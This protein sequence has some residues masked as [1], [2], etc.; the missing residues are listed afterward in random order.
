[1]KILLLSDLHIPTRCSIDELKTIDFDVYDQ[2]FIT[3]D[4]TSI[5]VLDFLDNQRPIIQAVH[6]NMDD[7][8]IK[9]K[10]PTT[11]VVELYGKT[12]GLI[13]GHQTGPAIPEK[14]INYF[15][16]HIDVLVFG[17]S[18][19]QKQ[20]IINSNVFINPGAFCKG[21]YAE[22]DLDENTLEI[23]LLHI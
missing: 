14:L 1:L 16:K 11:L 17:H 10:L 2:I 3:G 7:F 4:L 20:L 15:N 8:Y 5:E 19:F 9:N 18:H 21:E 12:F 23:N 13:H 22:I 6:G